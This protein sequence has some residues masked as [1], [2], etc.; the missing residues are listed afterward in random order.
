M[1]MA[2]GF[3]LGKDWNFMR[4]EMTRRRFVLGLSGLAIAGRASRVVAQSTPVAGTPYA[5]EIDPATF[6]TTIDN[7]F[8]PL[9]PGMRWVY[10]GEADGVKQVNTVVV[11]SDTKQLMGVT[12]VAVHDTVEEGGD[13]TE[14]TIDWYAQDM[15]G[16]VWYFGE[17]TKELKKGKVTSTEGSWQAGK[18][19]AQPGIA[20]G[21]KPKPKDSYR[22]EYLAGEAE[23]MAKVIRLDARVSVPFGTY[24]DVLVTEE[25]TPLEPGV[26][27]R[28]YYAQGVGMISSKITK[29]GDEHFELT[30]FESG[31]ATPEASRRG[32]EQASST[33]AEL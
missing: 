16:N 24:T 29:G 13:L 17:D 10:E 23:D 12:C 5:P 20:L 9:V 7:P 4:T 22:Q 33:G 26:R 14:D 1:G 8:L 25:W 30:K 28:K 31:V 32:G 27:E 11:T 18:D 2:I 19:G 3:G 21:A 15:D 6:T